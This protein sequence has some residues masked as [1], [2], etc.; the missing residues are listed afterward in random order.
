MFRRFTK[1]RVAIGLSA[2]AALALAAGAYAYFTSAGT[3][4]GSATVGS[5]SGSWGVSVQGD[6]SDALYPGVGKASLPY[7]LTNNSGGQLGL[8]NVTVAIATVPAGQTGA[9]DAE[10]Y[11]STTQAYSDISGCKASWF[12]VD[13][14][15]GGASD[16]SPTVTYN[17]VSSV[18]SPS[19]AI[20]VAKSG[21]VTGTATLQLLDANTPQDSCQGAAP[22]LIVTAGNGSH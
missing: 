13:G 10:S 12:S 8:Q 5:T 16:T 3:G 2:V 22:A 1:K 18:A 7:T 14:G 21:Q 11:N 15:A 17:S 19:A 4:T 20:D 6:T 9:G